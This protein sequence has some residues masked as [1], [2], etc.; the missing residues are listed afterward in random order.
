M[1]YDRKISTFSSFYQ[2]SRETILSLKKYEDF[3]IK[4]N[5]NLNLIGKSTIR[6]PDK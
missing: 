2:V 3:L 4:E 5:K 6:S 1:G